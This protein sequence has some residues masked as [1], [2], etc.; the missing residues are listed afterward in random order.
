MD[1]SNELMGHILLKNN[2]LHQPSSHMNFFAVKRLSSWGC[3]IFKPPFG[4]FLEGGVL[5]IFYKFTNTEARLRYILDL[6]T[7]LYFYIVHI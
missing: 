5:F 4:T 1:S 6:L 2:Y 3:D 7:K